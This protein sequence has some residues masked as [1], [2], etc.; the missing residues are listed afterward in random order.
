MVG[1]LEEERREGGGG[2]GESKGGGGR[3]GKRFLVVAQEA[4]MKFGFRVMGGT[5]WHTIV[6]WRR[7]DAVVACPSPLCA[8]H[9]GII[10]QNT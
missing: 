7:C 9:D 10:R 8:G 1:N 5:A 2:E 3:S 4:S 6:V